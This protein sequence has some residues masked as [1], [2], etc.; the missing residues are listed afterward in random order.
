MATTRSKEEIHSLKKSWLSD[1]CWDIYDTEGF[2]AHKEE[3]KAFQ[4]ETELQW[5]ERALKREAEEMKRLGID[6]QNTY[7]YL[8]RLEFQVHSI[9]KRIVKLEEKTL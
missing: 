4:K 1:P 7:Q 5:A 2:E 3:L 6:N 8:K 9:E